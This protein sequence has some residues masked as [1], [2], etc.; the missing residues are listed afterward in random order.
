MQSLANKF[1]SNNLDK[2][3]GKKVL[4]RAS[5]NVP[6]KNGVPLSRFRI[7]AAL[8]SIKLLRELSSTIYIIAHIGRDKKETLYPVYKELKKDIPELKFVSK[9]EFWS[10]KGEGI[11]LFEN[12]RS[13]D[14][15]KEN[16]EHFA[17]HL[18][19]FADFFVQDAFAVLHRE[20]A[21]VV[22]LPKF[23][24]SFLGLQVEKEIKALSYAL[25]KGNKSAFVLG[26][27]KFASKEKLIKKFLKKYDKVLLVGAL[28]NEA[29]AAKGF[30]VGSSKIEDGQIDK[31]VLLSPKLFLPEQFVAYDLESGKKRISDGTD[32]KKTEALYDAFA[33]EGFLENIDFALW[34]GPFGFYERGFVEGSKDFAKN[35]YL[36]NIETIAG[37]GDTVAVIQLLK[38]SS[39]ISFM[40][41]GGG[42]M[43][44]FLEKGTL[45][46]IDALID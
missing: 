19:E 26:G 13:F 15:E 44:E 30:N 1:L 7:D 3:K 9:E 35:L 36:N 37:G 39:A 43:L 16:D 41:T 32:V 14:E 24:P 5:L 22:S 11:Y 34:N 8:K 23:L 29:L 12:L 2:V 6:L 17:K 20:H 38:A 46:G 18:A 27:S 31:E 21:S 40:S 4:L 10:N 25:S 33:P 42:A 28:A 45:P